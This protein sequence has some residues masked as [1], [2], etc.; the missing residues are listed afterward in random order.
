MVFMLRVDP[1]SATATH[2]V[3]RAPGLPDGI[4]GPYAIVPR[5]ELPDVLTAFGG[6][7][8]QVGMWALEAERV[9]AHRARILFETD[10]KSIPN[11]LG[12]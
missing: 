6:V 2:A 9:A 4:G 7:H 1:Q 12:F 5:T 3:V 10:H 8:T 11:E